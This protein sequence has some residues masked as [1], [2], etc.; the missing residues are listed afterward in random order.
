MSVFSRRGGKCKHVCVLVFMCVSK[1]FTQRPG[2]ARMPR[3]ISLYPEGPK[4]RFRHRA[5]TKCSGLGHKGR[6]S[7]QIRTH[8]AK[9][10]GGLGS[11]PVCVFRSVKET[12]TGITVDMFLGP[13]VA[14][15]FSI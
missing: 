8:S 11:V 6:Q 12:T 4:K 9:V 5:P 10:R 1:E 14:M 2:A 7:M 13:L 3:V 15:Y